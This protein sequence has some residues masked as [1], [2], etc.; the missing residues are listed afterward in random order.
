MVR[1]WQEIGFHE[2]G[3]GHPGLE[4]VDDVL[5]EKVNLAG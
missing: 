2:K 5:F 4:I 3:N 1:P